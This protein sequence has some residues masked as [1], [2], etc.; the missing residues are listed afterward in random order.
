MDMVWLNIHLDN[1]ASKMTAK[2]VD[3]VVN[4]S[5]HYAL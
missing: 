4:F 1:L 3:A 2:D 5:T